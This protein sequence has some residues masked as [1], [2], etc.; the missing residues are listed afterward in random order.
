MIPPYVTLGRTAAKTFSMESTGY[1]D[2]PKQGYSIAAT[3]TFDGANRYRYVY[4]KRPVDT[5]P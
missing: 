4:Y 3:I 2:D 5:V 1:I